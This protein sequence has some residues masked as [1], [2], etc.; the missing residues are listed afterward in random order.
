MSSVEKLLIQ[1][2][3]SVDP[4][5]PEVIEFYSP[6]TLIVGSNG[7]GKTTIIE[8]LRYATT[9]EYP[10]NTKS[11]NAFVHDPKIAN[12]REVKAKVKLRFR[13]VAGQQVTCTRALQ[14]SQQAKQAKLKT[15]ENVLEVVSADGQKNQISKK[16]ADLDKEMSIHLGVSKS[17]LDYVIF[18]HQEDSNWPLS[19][20]RSLKEKFDNIFSATRYTKALE[21]M[22]KYRRDNKSQLEIF[23]KEIEHLTMSKQAADDLRKQLEKE[24]NRSA[25]TEERIEAIDQEMQPLN[26]ELSTLRKKLDEVGRL[27]AQE[28]TKRGQLELLRGAYESLR[29]S[30]PVVFENETD[31]QLARQLQKFDRE[32][33]QLQREL[34]GKREQ[35]QDLEGAIGADSQALSKLQQQEGGLDNEY[36]AYRNRKEKL[37]L[38][39]SQMAQSHGI[40]GFSKPS[41][42]QSDFENFDRA[43]EAL[44]KDLDRK[45]KELQAKYDAEY[46]ALT[47]EV[48]D[49]RN[50]ISSNQRE[51]ALVK[52]QTDNYRKQ[53]A[54]TERQLDALKVSE[55]ELGAKSRTHARLGME[56]ENFVKD[57]KVESKKK[58]RADLEREKQQLQREISKLQQDQATIARQIAAR[59]KVESLK[60]MRADYEKESQSILEKHRE[61]LVD[62]MHSTNVPEDPTRLMKEVTRAYRETDQQLSSAV[63]ALQ[64]VQVKRQTLEKQSRDL[65]SELGGLRARMEANRRKVHEV[66]GDKDLDEAMAGLQEDVYRLMSKKEQLQAAKSVYEMLRNK[67]KKHSCCP[68]CRTS[69]DTDEA[70]A[71]FEATIEKTIGSVPE[72]TK[73]FENEIELATVE[74]QRQKDLV[75]SNEEVKRLA[76]EIPAKEQT[77]KD[78]KAK[79]EEAE[80]EEDVNHCTQVELDEKKAQLSVLLKAVEEY[81]SLCAKVTDTERSIEDE[82][83]K[84]IETTGPFQTIEEAAAAIDDANQKS[85]RLE[86]LIKRE[87]EAIAEYNRQLAEYESQIKDLEM[88]IHG[89]EKDLRLQA[90]LISKRDTLTDSIRACEQKTRNLV[91]YA[92]PLVQKFNQKIQAQQERKEEHERER[93]ALVKTKGVVENDY[94]TFCFTFHDIK[95]Y[96]DKGKEKLLNDKR[97]EIAARQAE[98]EDK[99][100][101]AVGL[102]EDIQTCQ[103]RIDKQ[104]IDHRVL[105]ENIHLR[106][107]AQEIQIAE[108]SLPELRRAIEGMGADRVQRQV[109]VLEQKINAMEHERTGLKSEVRVLGDNIG[110]LQQQLNSQMYRNVHQRYTNTNI[111]YKTA[112]LAQ[113]DLEKYQKALDNAIMQFHQLKM[114]E[115]NKIIKEL[116]AN[117]YSGSDIDRIEIR[118]EKDD[119]APGKRQYNYRVVMVKENT[120]LDMKGRCSAGQKVLASLIIRLALAETFCLHCGIMALDEPTANL[121]H[122][123]IEK[124]ANALANIV[125]SRAAQRN[126]QLVVITHDE[127][128]VKYLARSG[129]VE[130]YWRVTRDENQHTKIRR[131]SFAFDG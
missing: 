125:R 10:P 121:D 100:A 131:A 32:V 74:Q 120:E 44:N 2:I 104:D 70:I 36:M 71:N 113:Q 40:N 129:C 19:D 88:C 55:V 68:L 96:V 92:E 25:Q 115:I 119:A 127:E 89:M 41:F 64:S 77:L 114:E 63:R 76:E 8:C 75:P 21:N 54:D 29:N 16:C 23:R 86:A 31:E 52:Q 84:L 106:Q 26:Q 95:D 47:I 57:E 82:Q 60:A 51:Q 80:E 43:L 67:A 112:E 117:T 73:R 111:D 4:E 61:G 97:K 87:D 98:V 24:R 5:H 46:D 28:E 109:E 9:G 11:G 39:V 33:G 48:N 59:G 83:R 56:K 90:E 93:G 12:Q 49:A 110:N 50:H 123:N 20:P 42:S 13:N 79:L 124:F 62:A 65:E 108:E 58:K 72:K 34:K 128:F 126:F 22:Q 91:T 116:W 107:K 102:R 38:S 27:Q 7:A 69:L 81:C 1:G 14:L 99:K 3:R 122:D 85:Q 66:V 53:L 30:L 130:Y 37:N 94:R 105:K 18:C 45:I 6:L 17:V 103:S 15:L 101:K 35:L 78:L 118:S